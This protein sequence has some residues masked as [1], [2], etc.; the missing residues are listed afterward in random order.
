MVLLI[1]PHRHHE[2]S[3]ILDD[4]YRLRCR[5]FRDRLNWQVHIQNGMERDGFDALRPVW[6]LLVTAAGSIGGCVRLLPSLGPTMLGE[7][8]S[9]LL[10]GSAVPAREDIWESSRFAV[11]L[12]RDTAGPSGLGTATYELFAAMVEFA[13]AHK[14]S[15]IMT[16]TDVR[17]ERILRRARWP[18]QRLGG[19]RPLGATTAVAGLLPIS[20]EVLR[21]L[22][23]AGR[24]CGPVLWQPAW[25]AVR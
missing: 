9:E 22:R 3:G 25:E 19:A 8:F 14:L 15:A 12:D 23:A 18:L 24:L 10:D 20:E 17:V 13:L 6:L 7:V 16:V 11:D 4:I 1:S 21:Q 5:V 2:F